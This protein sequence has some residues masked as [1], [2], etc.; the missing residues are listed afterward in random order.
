MRN[1]I[2]C[3]LVFL[4]PL[5]GHSQTKEPS[6]KQIRRFIEKAAITSLFNL[7]AGELAQSKSNNDSFKKFGEVMNRDHSLLLGELEEL[8]AKNKTVVSRKLSGSE[9]KSIRKL[10]GKQGAE[11]DKKFKTS[12]AAALRSVIR[13]YQAASESQ[14]TQISVFAYKYLPLLEEELQKIHDL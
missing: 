8:A 7:T 14:D 4:L 2:L 13:E 3:F 12:V 6:N 10:S 9:R 1:A 11:F 5:S